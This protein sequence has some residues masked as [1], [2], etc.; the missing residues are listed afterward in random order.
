[1]NMKP[2]SGD[3]LRP[4]TTEL[5]GGESSKMAFVPPEVVYRPVPHQ[6]G[7]DEAAAEVVWR[8]RFELA[9]DPSVRFGLDVNGEI[10]LG[11]EGK[12]PAF[13]DLSPYDAEML[14]VS[15]CH[16][17][18][19]PTPINL[20][21]IDLDS[22]NGT[23]RNG[24]MI[25]ANTPYSLADGDILTLGRLELV[26][27]I[28]RRPRGRTGLLH[29]KA[30]VGEALMQMA[31]AITSQLELE[32]VLNQALEMAMSLTMADEAAIW[33]V[34][35]QT[36]EFFLEGARGVEDREP[37]YMHLPMADSI[38]GEVLT[39]G[40]LLR[41]SRTDGEEPIK[42]TTGHL[43]EAVLYVPLIL[44]CVAL[45]VLMV[46]HRKEGSVFSKRDEKLLAAIG[47][48]S[49]IAVQN[50]RLIRDLEHSFAEVRKAQS[51]LVQTARLAALGELAAMIAH[52]IN[53]PLTT[54]LG[55]AEMLMQD[56]PQEHAGHE[57]AAAVY[58]AGQ[59]A[60][61]VVDRLL[62]L[63][64]PATHTQPLDVND[65]IQAALD[66]VSGRLQAAGNR[67]TVDMAAELP[68]VNALPGQLE[69]VWLNLLMNSH[70]AMQAGEPGAIGVSTAL[71][72]DGQAI[73][74][75]VWDTGSGISPEDLEH[76]FDP[77]FTT[78]PRDMGTGLGLYI[79]KQIVNQHKGHISITS[80]PGQGTRVI[81]RL[82]VASAYIV[83]EG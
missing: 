77:F 37:D 29:E 64:Q 44:G 59:R 73:E 7:V 80:E 53:N 27:S 11:R 55:D 76:V 49:A 12:G 4:E 41:V 39:T 17:R 50:A 25:G 28:V 83:E 9:S 18:M 81:V 47:D 5:N 19:H 70:D 32:E 20:F 60:K 10:E 74:V 52:Q 75:V 26:V 51:R 66:L 56:L 45:G 46:A 62:N 54:I 1:M 43:V 63:A 2:T 23:R 24:R 67:L 72:R 16:L 61:T 65:T 48:V 57:S 33:L 42:V 40:E 22:T 21:I 34:D 15:R 8:V 36:G 31:K 3:M 30:D 35:E 68:V 58:R 38:A 71:I 13:V 82:P 14:G 69:D 78:K 79:C 6:D